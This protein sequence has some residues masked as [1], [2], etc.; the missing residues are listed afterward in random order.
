MTRRNAKTKHS[1]VT[2]RKQEKVRAKNS[3]A[4][5]KYRE[6]KQDEK[7]QLQ[8][9]AEYLAEEVSKAEAQRDALCC[10]VAHL[11]LRLR[12]STLKLENHQK[13][14][15]PIYIPAIDGYSNLRIGETPGL[16]LRAVYSPPKRWTYLE[17]MSLTVRDFALIR[18]D[19]VL[20]AGQLLLA[21]PE[22]NEVS[23]GGRHMK[24]LMKESHG[25]TAYLAI[26]RPHV[27]HMLI[28]CRMDSKDLPVPQPPIS[29]WSNILRQLQLSIQQELALLT[30][31]TQLRDTNRRLCAE[32]EQLRQAIVG[33]IESCSQP[34]AFTE[35]LNHSLDRYHWA[36]LV[37]QLKENLDKLHVA[38]S[39]FHVKCSSLWT[40]EDEFGPNQQ[41]IDVFQDAR[42]L[43][44]AWPY[45]P[46]VISCV[47]AIAMKH[48][49]LQEA[50][51]AD[52]A[53]I[54]QL[55]ELEDS[56]ELPYVP[57]CTK[58]IEEYMQHRFKLSI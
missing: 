8:E 41:G 49:V 40:M 15:E 54:I 35:G 7:K 2:S 14:N 21:N 6:R 43:T 23:P 1:S 48:G 45:Y 34:A 20:K 3:K 26:H 47:E 19:I 36:K 18:K 50:D 38:K 44:L 17:T 13:V 11:D 9:H 56:L 39:K 5:K 33:H 42:L 58:L 24:E 28:D 32:R 12:D 46:K 16:M 4:Q 30:S 22:A 37:R 51:E 25:I 31:Y 10:A 52:T 55:A 57:P 27:L 53:S 29:F